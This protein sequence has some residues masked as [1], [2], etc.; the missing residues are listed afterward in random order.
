MSDRSRS[1]EA[2]I[3][4]SGG[5]I[6]VVRRGRKLARRLRKEG[7][8]NWRVGRTFLVNRFRYAA[9]ANPYAVLW[10]NPHEVSKRLV[11][12]WRGHQP[13]GTIVGGDWDL[14]VISYADSVKFR[15]LVER[16]ELGI[17]WEET[18]LFRESF[19]T[20]LAQ[21]GHVGGLRSLAELGCYYRNHVDRLYS[22]MESDGFQPPSLRKRISPVYAYIGRSGEFLWG[23]GGNHRLGIAKLLDLEAIPVRIHLRHELWQEVR[24]R[25]AVDG[26]AALGDRF[27]RHPDL[28][29]LL[30]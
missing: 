28:T 2:A 20:R 4:R 23:P 21:K 3:G 25:V 17:P 24:E 5:V 8:D 26:C 18:S 29:D 19:R 7:T 10:I 14:K 12:G 27:S 13:P 11:G 6:R 30:R 22:I 1:H 9:V 15:G 16:F